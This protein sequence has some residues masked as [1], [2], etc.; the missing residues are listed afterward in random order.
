MKLD[1]KEEFDLIEH[2][3]N[4][5]DGCGS[6]VYRYH[7]VRVTVNG[8]SYCVKCNVPE[9]EEVIFE[10]FSRSIFCSKCGKI[11]LEDQ[12]IP[13]PDINDRVFC[14]DEHKNEFYKRTAIKTC[15]C[16]GIEI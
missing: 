10:G 7:T 2:G 1:L 15:E 8:R 11:V 14:S 3:I 9:K 5:C 4:H 6:A 13:N 12:R 16:C